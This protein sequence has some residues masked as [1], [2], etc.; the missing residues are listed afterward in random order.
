VTWLTNQNC[1]ADTLGRFPAAALAAEDV[2]LLLALLPPV[3]LAVE[4]ELQA[5]SSADAAAVALTRPVPA[6]SR[7]RVGPSC[8]LS[9]CI[10]SSTLGST[11]P[12]G[13]SVLSLE[14]ELLA[15]LLDSGGP[16]AT[17]TLF[18]RLAPPVSFLSFVALLTL[19]SDDKA[20]RAAQ[21]RPV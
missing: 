18:A 9:V 14:K 16:L 10:A 20:T 15:S 8:M 13:T 4:L 19:T 5:A 1:H 6:S 21:A 3:A 11:L 17:F 7:R 2:L 12:I